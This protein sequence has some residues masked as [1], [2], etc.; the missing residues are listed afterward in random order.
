M[1]DNTIWGDYFHPIWTGS[2]NSGY[3]AFALVVD[4]NPANGAIADIHN[5]YGESSRGGSGAPNYSATNTRRAVLDPSGANG[6]Q[7]NKDILVKYFMIQTNQATGTG[8]RTTF[9][10]KWE[11][12]G[13]R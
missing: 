7:G 13:S 3:G 4:F 12:V 1:Y 5:L 9:N 8:P 11:Y 2:D 10:E 6:V